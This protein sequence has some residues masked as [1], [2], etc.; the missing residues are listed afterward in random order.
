MKLSELVA[1][2]DATDD[3]LT[4]FAERSSR[5]SPDSPAAV[6]TADAGAPEGLTYLL[7]VYLAKEAVEVW[8]QWREDRQPSL[9]EKCK[10]IIWYAEHDA[11]TPLEADS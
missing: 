2:L 9:A 6:A 8:S 4:I 5:W 3:D 7:E 11:Y 10:A 1:T